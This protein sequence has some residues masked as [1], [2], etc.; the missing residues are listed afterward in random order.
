MSNFI[1]SFADAITRQEGY[2]PGSTAYNNNNPGNI[3]DGLAPGK[4]QRIWPSLPIDARGFVIYPTPEAGRAALEKDLTIKMNSGLSLD[5]AISM[6]APPAGNDT[7]TYQTHVAS[8]LGVDGSQSLRSLA[9]SWSGSAAP[10]AV[11]SSPVDSSVDPLSVDPAAGDPGAE[12][13]PLVIG[14]AVLLAAA[15]WLLG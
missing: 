2:F 7:G 3:W 11:P 5:Q 10:A 4:T 9:A 14:G 13:M 8:W 1:Q 12:A 6:Y 15:A